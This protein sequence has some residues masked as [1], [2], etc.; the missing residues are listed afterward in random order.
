MVK[1][2][3]LAALVAALLWAAPV[4]AAGPYAAGPG[5]RDDPRALRAARE[6]VIRK[7]GGEVA[8]PLV[9]GHGETAVAALRE[10]SPEVGRK[11]C[12]WANTGALDK[13]PRP[14]DVLQ[15]VAQPNAGDDVALWV[16]EHGE[17]ELA[18]SDALGAFCN[19]SLD[20]ALGLQPLGKLTAAYRANRL[21]PGNQTERPSSP[22]QA[23]ASALAALPDWVVPA[24]VVLAAVL[25]VVAIKSAGRGARRVS[26]RREG[27]REAFARSLRC[28]PGG[29][30]G[31]CDHAE[32]MGRHRH[33][34]L[35]ARDAAPGAYLRQGVAPRP[36]RHARQRA[37]GGRPPLRGRNRGG[38]RQP[39]P[40][41]FRLAGRG[42][43]PP[44]GGAFG[45]SRTPRPVARAATAHGE[46]VPPAQGAPGRGGRAPARGRWEEAEEAR[47]R[48]EQLWAADKA[49]PPLPRA[50]P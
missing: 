13:L 36:V 20:V 44:D 48:F 6:E 5:G 16:I 11:L 43:T 30:T 26:R 46:A 38:R 18:D 45:L 34:H 15:A 10:C 40:G 32:W 23:G 41:A 21:S 14:D 35:P 8:R 50:P 47:R 42:G 19:N 7:V 33:R 22:Q 28:N 49:N 2:T 9:E 24:G 1:T 3:T 12:E 25:V 37:C 29:M 39:G 17:K 4:R 31:G 27:N